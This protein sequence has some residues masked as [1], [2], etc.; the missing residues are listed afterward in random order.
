MSPSILLN[1]RPIA[2][3]NSYKYLGVMFASKGID[4]GSQST[5]LSERVGR[6]L[7]ALRWYSASW[8]PRIRFNILKSILLPTLEYSLPLLYG[9]FLKDRKSKAW[10]TMNTA[11]NNCLQWIAG[12]AANR[13]HVTCHLLGLLPLKDR[14]QHLHSRFYLH[15]LSMDM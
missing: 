1:N 7:G 5:L 3:V 14:A 11:Y 12:S 13:P 8:C 9:H 6:Q 4:F 15:L 2:F 10:V